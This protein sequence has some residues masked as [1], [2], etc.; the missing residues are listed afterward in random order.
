MDSKL[1]SI[2]LPS[3]NMENYL[4]R[5]VDSLIVKTYL[6]KYEII[7]VNDGSKDKT[8]EI[9]NNYKKIYNNTIVVVDKENGHYGSAVNAGLKVAQGK[10][11]KVL[12]ADDWFDNKEFEKLLLKL[13]EGINADV[14]FTHWSIHDTRNNSIIISN[15]HSN[16]FNK[17]LNIDSIL[18]DKHKYSFYSF[19]GIAY[20]TEI[21]KDMN[22][23]QT[24]GICYTDVEYAYYPI[25]QAR[26]AIFFDINL[27]QY[28]I[29]RDGQTITE[30]ALKRNVSHLYKVAKRMTDTF[31]YNVSEVKRF[32]QNHQFN[33]IN[34]NLYFSCLCLN[35]KSILKEIDLSY[36]DHKLKINVP[37]VYNALKKMTCMKIPYVRLWRIFGVNS[38]YLYRLRKHLQI[39][40]ETYSHQH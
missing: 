27:Y 5:C 14:I 37:Y 18:T 22:Y 26:T 25:L 7:I 12:D 34:Q 36:I 31:E 35:K 24:E 32:F 30:D 1:I 11:F 17:A 8:L 28:F 38:Y 33:L 3:Y 2:V 21:L 19:Y 16:T 10:Y 4:P 23:H 40:H 39:I 20:K 29:G 15:K 6:G 13:E 9:A